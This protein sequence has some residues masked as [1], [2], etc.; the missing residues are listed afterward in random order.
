MITTEQQER[1]KKLLKKGYAAEVGV[2]L[3]QRGV[4]NLAGNDYDY[5]TISAVFC[6]NRENQEI[7]SAIFDLYKSKQSVID[8]RNQLLEI[9]KPEAATS[10]SK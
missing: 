3:Q 7:E 2:L 4:K 5:R 9:K 1:L 8:E 10:G 6:G